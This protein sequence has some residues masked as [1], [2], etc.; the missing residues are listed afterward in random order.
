M[1]L[2]LDNI[3]YFFYYSFISIQCFFLISSHFLLQFMFFLSKFYIYKKG[4]NT[5]NAM[6]D[7]R[8]KILYEGEKHVN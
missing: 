4:S 5:K 3:R 6:K 1:G 7:D 2:I 8:Y